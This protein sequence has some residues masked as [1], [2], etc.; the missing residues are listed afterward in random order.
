MRAMRIQ[1]ME[2]AAR[3]S[4][5]ESACRAEQRRGADL[6]HLQSLFHI[7]LYETWITATAKLLE[8]VLLLHPPLLTQDTQP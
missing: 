4:P 8:Q 7:F 3:P 6:G 1:W 5:A 2:L